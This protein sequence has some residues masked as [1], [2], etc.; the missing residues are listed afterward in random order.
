LEYIS[1]KEASEN[2]GIDTSNIGK[3]CRKGKIEG[4]KLVGKSWLIPKSA[5]KPIDG[6]TKQAK[7]NPNAAVFRFPLY[8]NFPEDSFVP[9]LTKEEAALRQA[10]TDFY[11]CEF[12]K[13]KAV[14]EALSENAESIY[15]K[16]C[17]QFFMCILSSIY[18]L[19]ISWDKYYCGLNLLLSTDFPHKKE[20]ELLLPWL[21]FIIGQFR[22]IPEKLNTDPA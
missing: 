19:N 8:V 1:V 17:A 16:I 6:R 4:A 20:M 5:Q 22:K 7:G 9:P 12:Q 10:Q 11:A 21:D 15:V 2:W 14:F 13:S 18:D 3:L